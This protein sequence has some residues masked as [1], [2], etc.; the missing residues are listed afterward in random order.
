MC[1]WIWH[2]VEVRVSNYKTSFANCN[3][4]LAFEFIWKAYGLRLAEGHC[5]LSFGNMIYDF[6]LWNKD[7]KICLVIKFGG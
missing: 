2:C 5:I 1:I 3:I 7:E 6:S 4:L